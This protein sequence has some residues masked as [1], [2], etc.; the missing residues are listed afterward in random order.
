MQVH[1][2]GS[3]PI[4]FFYRRLDV[5]NVTLS[6]ITNA[7]LGAVVDKWAS[8]SRDGFHVVSTSSITIIL[9]PGA[10]SI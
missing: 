6:H 8:L 7:C 5:G 10:L 9:V 2:H 1:Q 3:C 4:L